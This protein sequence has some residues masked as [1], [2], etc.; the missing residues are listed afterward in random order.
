MNNEALEI[1]GRI[2]TDMREVIKD[3]SE[4]EHDFSIWLYENALCDLYISN[5]E[6][7]RLMETMTQIGP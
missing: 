6:S 7:E 4:K 5:F 1:P 3:I 2:N